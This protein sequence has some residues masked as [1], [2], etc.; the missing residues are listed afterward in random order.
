MTGILISRGVD[1]ISGSAVGPSRRGTGFMS[2]LG[3]VS[4]QRL[5]HSHMS[6]GNTDEHELGGRFKEICERRAI[7]IDG[8]GILAP[9][10]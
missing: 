6:A 10:R 9:G 5:G 8:N 3:E 4:P 1:F 7:R 2:A